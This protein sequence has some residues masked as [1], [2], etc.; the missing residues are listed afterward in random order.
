MQLEHSITIPAPQDVA[1]AVTV[2]VERWPEWTPTMQSVER[3]ERGPFGVGS[4]AKIKQPQL[5]PAIWRVTSHTPGERF[6]W[7]TRNR[8]MR[9]V[10]THEIVATSG[11]CA[12]N[13]RLEVSGLVAMLL[14]PIIRRSAG[15]ALAKENL[16]LRDRCQSE[17]RCARA[18]V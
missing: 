1:W 7:E 15:R 3:L 18:A 14:W 4:T 2:D 10:A 13:L 5:P 16:C 8:G 6:T 12:S 11:G 9:M 17:S